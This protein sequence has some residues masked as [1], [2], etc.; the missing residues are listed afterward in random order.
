MFKN[1][2][3]GSEFISRNPKITKWMT[4]AAT[5]L[6]LL[7]LNID[8]FIVNVALPSI[9]HD[10]HAPV[11]IVS[12]TISTYVLMLGVLP[13]GLGKIGDIWGQ[14]KC[15]LGGLAL[16]TL[17]SL[18]CGLASSI[19]W[20]IA[21]RTLQGIG[22]AAITPGTLA[23]LIRAF[24]RNQKGFAIGLN[25]GIGGLGLVAGPVL[26]GVIIAG[27][28][29]RWIFF[30]NIPLGLLAIML[31]AVFVVESQVEVKSKA[32][33]W[34]GM[35]CLCMGLFPILFAFTRAE[36]DGFDP[37]SIC[38]LL[39]GLAVIGLFVFVEKKTRHPLIEL[40]LFKNAA[41]IMP[42]ISL[43]LFSAALFGSQ[44]YWNLFFQN[45]WGFTPL[46]GGLAFLPATVLI[47]ALTPFSGIISQKSERHLRYIVMLGVILVGFSFFYVTRINSQSHFVNGFLPALL[48]RGVGIPILMASTSLAIMNAVS[49][50]QSGLAAGML[51]IFKNIG[52]AMGVTLLGQTYIHEVGQ[53]LSLLHGVR[54][55]YSVSEIKESAYQFIS[56]HDH[57]RTMTA[58][59]IIK[60][61]DKMSMICMLAFI[62]AFISAFLIKSHKERNL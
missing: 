56:S 39:G 19:G 9:G 6:G 32:M 10:L 60:G 40:S 23:I 61:F 52:T 58:V 1:N 43:F 27:S 62:P 48:I 17:A 45:F 36:S 46:Q 44:P 24:P 55:P 16:F 2:H 29:W 28:S 47:A 54:S 50:D 12:W 34:L 26:G 35:L 15:Y 20:L 21:F 49:D 30:V 53:R 37:L 8:L 59:A 22:A 57:F 33:D 25:G 31:T 38:S 51:N 13:A 14:K 3:T 41:F 4:L 42:C 5:C 7:L 18:A 11:N